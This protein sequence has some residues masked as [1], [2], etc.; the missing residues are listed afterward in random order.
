MN[1][2]ELPTSLNIGGVEYAIRTDFRAILDILIAMNDPE[3]DNQ[4]KSIVM[5]KIL[6]VDY[7]TI[8]SKYLNEACEKAC[9][10]IDCGQKNDGKKNPRT[11]DWKQDA[12]IIIPAVNSVAHTEVRAIPNL[13]WWTFFG[14]F[15][16]VRE[17]L[18]SS[19]INIRQKKAK[20]KKLE[21]W[22]SE[23]YKENQ[24]IIDFKKSD[25]E[26]IKQEKGNLLKWL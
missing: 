5:L 6:Y 13:H 19:V 4:C 21:K 1:G 16:E 23:F 7:Q 17:S 11:I 20:H 15:M 3:L 9:E 14:Y 8:P 25:S 2:Y 26:E 10:F 24:D 18:L 12:G 22:E